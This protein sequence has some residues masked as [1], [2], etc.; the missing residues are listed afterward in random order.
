MAT[1]YIVGAGQVGCL[2]D[3]GP[4]CSDTLENA[5]EHVRWYLEG[6]ELPDKTIERILDALARE[7]IYYFTREERGFACADYIEVSQEQGECPEQED[8]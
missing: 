6:G 4:E 2:Y 5:L 8:M 3:W 7:G 1:H